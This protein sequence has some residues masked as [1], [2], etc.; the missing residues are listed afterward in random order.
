[1]FSRQT[2]G[3]SPERDPQAQPRHY[4]IPRLGE[5]LSPERDVQA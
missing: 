2:M 4:A 3:S 5:L 1:M